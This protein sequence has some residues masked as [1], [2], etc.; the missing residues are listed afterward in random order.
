M[1]YVRVAEGVARAGKIRR[2]HGGDMGRDEI[3]SALHKSV[4]VGTRRFFTAKTT[5]IDRF[6]KCSAQLFCLWPNKT[7]PNADDRYEGNQG[8]Y[9]VKWPNWF[10][11]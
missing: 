11:G 7:K 3:Y 5:S 8:K 2:S 4:T 6:C 1:L 9:D 10:P